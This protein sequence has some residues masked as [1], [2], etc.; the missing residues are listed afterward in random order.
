MNERSSVPDG[1]GKDEKKQRNRACAW[2]RR[3]GR[4]SL[5]SGCRKSPEPYVRSL[6]GFPDNLE[7]TNAWNEFVRRTK[8]QWSG[9]TPSSRICSEHFLP[10]CYKNHMAWSM[11]WVRTLELVDDFQVPTIYP[12]E[13]M[14]NAASPIKVECKQERSPSPPVSSAMTEPPRCLATVKTE[15]GQECDVKPECQVMYVVRH[16]ASQTDPPPDS[17]V[18]RSVGTQLTRK[19]H[20]RSTA[21]QVKPMGRD[22][23]VCT[24]PLDS[25]MLFLQPILVKRPSKRRR[26]SQEDVG[27]GTSERV[28][29][30]T[31]VQDANSSV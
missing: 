22:C 19:H 4:L 12:A 23:G 13:I 3:N 1:G 2:R 21:S 31:A 20:Y 16:V 25:P 9:N 14:K 17:P 15:P 8:P 10:A 24:E 27:E 7:T 5:V 30:S 11:G 29:A 18:T 6:H 26:V 28:T